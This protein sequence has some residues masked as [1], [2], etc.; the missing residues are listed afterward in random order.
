MPKRR[1]KDER[2]RMLKA[3]KA[4][5][6]PVI[7][8]MSR[9]QRVQDNWALLHAQDIA[10]QRAA[11]LAVV[12]CLAP[13]FRGAAVRQ[14]GFLLRGLEEADSS[15]RRL[16]IPLF[17]LRG[18]PGRELP[19]F[20]KRCG[21]SELVTDFDP[22]RVKGS[23]KARIA[24]RISIPFT[25]VDAHNIVP[26]WI[27]STKA[28]YGAYTLRPKLRRL[29]PEYLGPFPA[30]KKHPFAWK[31]AVPAITWDRVLSGLP[32]DRSVKET[33][34]LVPGERAAVKALRAFI[35]LKLAGYDTL[36]NDP[37]RDGQSNLSPYLHF[38]QLSAQRVAR[39]VLRSRAPERAKEAFLEELI[40]RR[41]LSDNFCLYTADYDRVSC[42]PRWAQQ[43]LAKHR[44]DRREYA[45]TLREFEEGRTHDELWNAAQLEMVRRGKMHGYLR[46]Y[47]AKK[48]LE[49]TRSPERAMKVAL[50]LNDKY[51]L[52]GRDPNGYAGIA[53]SIGGV[54]DRPW[55]ERKIFGMIRYM[56]EKGCRSKFDVDDYI[57]KIRSMIKT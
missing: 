28:E 5:S 23:G 18:E 24:E 30:M 7:Y 52:D 42:F 15:L 10:L 49:W 27:A 55:G 43:T 13:S 44:K 40:T 33:D 38:G 39:E 16:D 50:F 21:A 8:W 26:C 1:V 12:F 29:L 37:S 53:W 31:T 32:V 3:G 34:W 14:Q 46:M 51:E 48:I 4:G 47:W 56:S 20:L 54:H 41:E 6:G 35:R 2:I 36:R 25:E 22:L 9:D 57:R 11:P 17:L 45:Y 19:R